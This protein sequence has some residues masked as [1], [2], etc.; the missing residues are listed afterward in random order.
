MAAIRDSKGRFI[1]RAAQAA[2]AAAVQVTLP[3]VRFDNRQKLQTQEY[4]S[5][6]KRRS[7][8]RNPAPVVISVFG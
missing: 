4:V 3:A 7:A 2:M 1:S 8:R 6:R 5:P